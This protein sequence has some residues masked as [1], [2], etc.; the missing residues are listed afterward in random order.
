MRQHLPFLP[1]LAALAGHMHGRHARE[2]DG[3]PLPDALFAHFAGMLQQRGYE[4]GGSDEHVYPPMSTYLETLA[5]RFHQ[6]Y[7]VHRVLVEDADVRAR[8]QPDAGGRRRHGDLDQRMG[9]RLR[10]RRAT[11]L[12]CNAATPGSS[13][14]PRHR[15]LQAWSCC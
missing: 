11:A 3:A 7:T 14:P 8:R 5:T 12:R 10:R 1:R 6:F 4:V 2:D 15:R 9:T 13:R